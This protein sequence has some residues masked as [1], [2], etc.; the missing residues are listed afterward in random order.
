MMATSAVI[1]NLREAVLDLAEKTSIK[2]RLR[3]YRE[4][5]RAH[6]RLIASDK[7]YKEMERR[8]DQAMI[9]TYRHGFA[10]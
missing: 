3:K 5:A 4:E 10:R 6:R 1:T 8:K 7:A 9:D 2:R